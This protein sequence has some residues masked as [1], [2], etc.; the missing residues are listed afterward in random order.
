MT[1]I[2]RQDIMNKL[3]IIEKEV[4]KIDVL[5]KKVIAM[6]D[7]VD[8]HEEIL[9]GDPKD[10]KDEG[11]LGAVR[12]GN[13]LLKLIGIIIVTSNGLLA[14]YLNYKLATGGQ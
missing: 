11:V 10:W 3:T 9:N 6:E 8:T 5:E 13:K 4:G 1:E 12:D 7:K 14:L 2:S